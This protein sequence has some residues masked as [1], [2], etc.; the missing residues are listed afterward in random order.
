MATV[1]NKSF[2]LRRKSLK[3]ILQRENGWTK[4]RVCWE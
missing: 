1:M 4:T 2:E 3:V